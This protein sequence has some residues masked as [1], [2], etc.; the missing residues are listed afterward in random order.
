MFS[1]EK[2]IAQTQRWVNDVVVGLNFCPFAAK[3]IKQQKVLY[4][5][6]T[7]P[8]PENII[9]Q[10]HELFQKLNNNEA[11][12]AILI[13]PEGYEIFKKY[14]QL[15]NIAETLIAETGYTG[16]YQVASFHPEYIF[17]GSNKNDAAN[18][19]N[20]SPYPMLHVLREN[21]LSE[22]VNKHPDTYKIPENNIALARK[23]GLEHM[24]QL[25]A[26]CFE[27]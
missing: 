1:E 4:A 17:E 23:L 15:V 16:I 7:N 21:D 18:Y 24:K 20:R 22:A 14:L 2:I 25:R 5:I 27:V 19:T 9:L 10:L 26:K 11:A 13:I 8:Q 6:A 12:T 3:E